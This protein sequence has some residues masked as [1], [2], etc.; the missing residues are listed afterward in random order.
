MTAGWRAR[1]PASLPQDSDRADC[2]A[3]GLF[4]GLHACLRL[5]GDVGGGAGSRPQLSLVWPRE[6]PLLLKLEMEGGTGDRDPARSSQVLGRLDPG[7]R[8]CHAAFPLGLGQVIRLDSDCADRER[9]RRSNRD[10]PSV[11]WGAC[12]MPSA[13]VFLGVAVPSRSLATHLGRALYT[14]Y[15][16]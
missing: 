10:Q 16:L 9:G 13:S 14:A 6:L 7:N 2:A 12:E 5:P 15:N 1:P 11:S 3:W 4:F 8:R